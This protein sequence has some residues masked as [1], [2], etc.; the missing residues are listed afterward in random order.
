MSFGHRIN[1]L[2]PIRFDSQGG[3]PYYTRPMPAD[4]SRTVDVERLADVGEVREFDLPY[5]ELP[6]LAAEL[7]SLEGV[8]RC[9][10]AFSR[11]RGFPVAD[12]DVRAR[13][14][15]R[16]QRCL[17][18]APLEVAQRSRVWHVAEPAAADRLEA[19]IEPV[20]APDGRIA[21]R[22]LVEEE[23]LLVV[24]LVPRHEDEADCGRVSSDEADVKQTPFAGL[25]EL[26]KRG[27]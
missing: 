10:V 16:C 7:A 4:W 13:L 8:A 14:P 26:L 1:G 5:A 23:L 17:Q 3:D 27:N 9:R 21:L 12:I 25:G 20:L 19:G 11:E 2:E 6:R 18:T 22:D 24:P 15:L